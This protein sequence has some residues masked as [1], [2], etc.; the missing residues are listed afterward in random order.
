MERAEFY[1]LCFLLAISVALVV[2]M[3]Y[4]LWRF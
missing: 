3:L 2:T 1:A 4:K